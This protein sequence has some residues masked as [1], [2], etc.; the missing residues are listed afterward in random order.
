MAVRVLLGALSTAALCAA[1]VQLV[2]P[3]DAGAILWSKAPSPDDTSAWRWAVAA[4]GMNIYVSYRDARR[5]GSIV[6]AWIDRE[7]YRNP[8]G[9]AK[10]IVELMQFDCARMATRRVSNVTVDSIVPPWQQELPGSVV[11]HVAVEVCV[12]MNA[13]V[14]NPEASSG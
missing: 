9:I 8:A 11:G 2:P 7:Y 6:T 14:L 1:S 4:P 10:S 3:A 12:K 13:H 5:S